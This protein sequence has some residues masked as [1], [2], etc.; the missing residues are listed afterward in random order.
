MTRSLSPAPQASVRSS[1]GSL[2][3]QPACPQQPANESQAGK[4]S[5]LLPSGLLSDILL[6]ESE[7]PVDLCSRKSCPVQLLIR[8]LLVHRISTFL[9][10]DT[11]L[12]IRIGKEDH[13]PIT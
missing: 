12:L 8:F 10:P 6:T 7:Q 4:G 13:I 3:G 5:S 1:L 9:F 2:L 11:S